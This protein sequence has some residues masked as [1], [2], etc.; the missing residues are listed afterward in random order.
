MM[1]G[2]TNDMMLFPLF[3]IMVMIAL[4]YLV[5]NLLRY[6]FFRESEGGKIFGLSDRWIKQDKSKTKEK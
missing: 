2:R 3:E 6:F 5:V 1:N 4:A